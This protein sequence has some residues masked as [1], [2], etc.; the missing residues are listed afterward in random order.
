MILIRVIEDHRAN[1]YIVITKRLFDFFSCS[2][3]PEV[4]E[5]SDGNAWYSRI[6][7]LIDQL[8]RKE[9]QV[10]PNRAEGVCLENGIE[11]QANLLFDVNGIY[12]EYDR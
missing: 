8:K 1:S 10:Y 9:K 7:E 4:Y 6:A 3:E 12:T 2:Q 11:T 5:S